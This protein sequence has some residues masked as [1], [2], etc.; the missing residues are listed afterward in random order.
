MEQTKPEVQ[1]WAEIYLERGWAAVPVDPSEKK[2]KTNGW[3][4]T[5]FSVPQFKLGWNIG[6]RLGKVSVGAVRG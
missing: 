6:L 3:Q 2:P 4:R 1:Q 5:D